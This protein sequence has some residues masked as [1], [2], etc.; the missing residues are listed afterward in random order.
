[1]TVVSYGLTA[2]IISSMTHRSVTTDKFYETARRNIHDSQ[3]HNCHPDNMIPHNVNSV[4]PTNSLIKGRNEPE[5]PSLGMA[6]VVFGDGFVYCIQLNYYCLYLKS[7]TV[8]SELN[9]KQTEDREILQLICD[10]YSIRKHTVNISNVTN[11]V[12]PEP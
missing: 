11:S 12:A 2:P 8:P 9:S 1:M 6:A 7:A 3:L 5:A 4:S 10:L